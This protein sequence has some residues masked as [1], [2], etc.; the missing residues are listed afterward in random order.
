MEMICELTHS[1]A[2]EPDPDQKTVTTLLRYALV[3]M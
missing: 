3:T 1:Q 2:F